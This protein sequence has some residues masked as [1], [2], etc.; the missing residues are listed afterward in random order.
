MSY[1]NEICEHH[2]HML[3][4][5]DKNA[6]DMIGESSA[7]SANALRYS[8]GDSTS[9]AHSADLSLVGIL[10]V[11]IALSFLIARR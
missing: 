10:C 1:L 9:G 6:T 4:P 11:A 7:T 2:I 3:M 5:S 8:D